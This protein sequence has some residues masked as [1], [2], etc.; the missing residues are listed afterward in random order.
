MGFYFA[1]FFSLFQIFYNT[2]ALLLQSVNE[3]FK[4]QP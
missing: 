4:A 3:C 1:V 2:R